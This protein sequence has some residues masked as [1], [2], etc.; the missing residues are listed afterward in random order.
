MKIAR[1]VSSLVVT[2]V[3]SGPISA[4]ALPYARTAAN[5][6]PTGGTVTGYGTYAVNYVEANPAVAAP[7]G[8]HV[9]S[10]YA[11]NIY[12]DSVEVGWYKRYGLANKQAFTVMVLNGYYYEDTLGA[13]AT[14][15]KSFQLEH[16]PGT[17]HDYEV[18]IGGSL[19]KTWR[20]TDIRSSYAR[21]GAERMYLGSANDNDGAWESLQYK[22][23]D[24][25]SW[26][27]WQYITDVTP[28]N[29]QDSEYHV[30]PQ[31]SLHK[32]QVLHN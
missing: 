5:V 13:I 17:G 27:Y 12:G 3:L 29:Y 14:G 8:Q 19:F 30:N 32:A 25:S 21:L 10:I 6:P 15:S 23:N 16:V 31:V 4:S 18:R 2:L 7:D 22:T 28:V 1:L 11:D 24:S 9:N 26:G 20:S